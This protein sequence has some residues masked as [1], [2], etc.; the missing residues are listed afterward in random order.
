MVFPTGTVTF[1][2]TDIEGSTRL[3]EEYPEAVKPALARHDVL[4][5]RSIE[6][7]G[8]VV[9]KTVGDAFC[10]AFSTA[11]EA[12]AGALD[13]QRL[14]AAESWP[15]GIRLQIRMALHTGSAE[16]RGGDYFGPSLNRVARLMAAGHGGQTLLSEVT[17]GLTI[18]ALPA[19]VSLLDL[20]RCRLKDLG[21]PEQVFQL[22]HPDLPAEF[23]PL[24]SLDNPALPNNLPQQV[25]SFI[26]REKE[27]ADIGAF[28]AKT[29]LLTLVAAGGSGKSRLALQVAADLLTGEGDGVWLAEFAPLSEP[30]L[31]PQAVA[32]ALGVSEEPSRPLA[33]T[34]L[35][36]LQSRRLLLILDN[37]E[38]LLLA[39][40]ALAAE[41]L[42]TCPHVRL[43][44]TS[45]EALNVAGE[46]LYRVPSLSLPDPKASCTPES[47]S[48]YEA[49]RLFMERARLVQPSFS[50]TDANA[51][52]VAQICWRLD[53]IPLA[54]EMAAARL[55]SLSAEQ[56][57][58]RL[59]DRFRLLTGGSHLLLPRQQ[60]LRALVDWS[61][62]LLTVS[63][64][65]VLQRLSVFAGGWTLEAAEQVCA[66]GV[67]EHWEVL[68]ILTSL[69]DKSL[70]LYE[71]NEVEAGPGRY[72]LLETIRQYAA[73][74]LRE[75]GGADAARTRHRNYFL[76]RA[77]AEVTNSD[78][79][80]E[81]DNFRAALDWSRAD[82]AGGEAGLR[83]TAALRWRWR[84]CGYFTEAGQRSGEALSHPGA[85][86]PIPARASAL[87]AAFRVP[88]DTSGSR[89]IRAEQALAISQS[90]GDEEGIAQASLSLAGLAVAR[91]EYD[92]AQRLYDRTLVLFQKLGNRAFEAITINDSA[93]VA[94]GLGDLEQARLL[95][96][97]SR[98]ICLEI[99]HRHLLLLRCEAW[100]KLRVHRAIWRRPRHCWPRR[101]HC[102]GKLAGKAPSR[103]WMPSPLSL[104][105][106]A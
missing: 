54:M 63:E 38:H 87:L 45:R 90:L 20:G 52:A 79:E 85:Q 22:L 40:A 37:C 31:V 44:A 14:I 28:L 21:R 25:T 1:L 76:G 95:L 10:A 24:K 4:V 92:L 48:Q 69:V 23:P 64:R 36:W 51:P 12:L 30:A 68:D 8:G 83:L 46:Q 33:K 67:V 6:T 82:P 73:D 93:D 61:Y 101:W 62:D 78:F 106:G 7:Q 2:F 3:W 17:Q 13:A 89:Q 15:D 16:E 103:F 57:M 77:E 55:R 41:I 49:V 74:R 19:A 11:P 88:G 65:A 86:V 94:S 34:L 50:V 84:D 43:L 27:L 18:D 70:I 5:R 53:G 66:D 91:T 80:R 71:E 75:D 72:R 97:Q 59:D 35:E 98:A 29:R 58:V 81:H 102:A 100:A 60:T 104:P 9:F 39:C 96:Q 32:D 47:L 56:V 26:G 105:S 42:R 99:G